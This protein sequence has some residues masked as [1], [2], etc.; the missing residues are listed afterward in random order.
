MSKK[1]VKLQEDVQ[2]FFL[3]NFLL[4]FFLLSDR[5]IYK[6]YE[7]EVEEFRLCLI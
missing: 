6:R 5:D 4:R 3:H 1:R 2:F 7:E